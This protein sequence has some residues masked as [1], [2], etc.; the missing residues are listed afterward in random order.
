MNFRIVAIPLLAAICLDTPAVAGGMDREEQRRRD[1]GGDNNRGGG[2][3]GGGENR[4]YGRPAPRVRVAVPSRP[5]VSVNIGN[6][7]P[8]YY[9]PSYYDRWARNAYRWSPVRY[10]PWGLISGSIG[11]AG[12]SA[13][14]AYGAYGYGAYGAP[15][16]RSRTAVFVREQL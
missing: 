7:G 6:R 15:Y 9:A 14:S 5:I 16:A 11:F 1:R 12:F 10:A 13:Y 8:R 2:N 4:R 3:R